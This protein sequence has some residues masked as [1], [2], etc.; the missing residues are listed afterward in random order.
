MNNR[1]ALK[2]IIG[3]TLITLFLVGC[4]GITVEPTAKP[5]IPPSPKPLSPKAILESAVTAME[6]LDSYHFEMVIHMTIVTEGATVETPLTFTGDFK[7]PDRLQGELTMD[8]LG[9]TIEMEVITI[10]GISY[11]KDPTSDEWQTTTE[12]TSPFTPE[13]FVGLEPD[14]IA[15]MEDLKLLGESVLG[16]APVYHLEGKLTTEVMENVLGE[17]EGEIKVE[18]WIGLEDGWIRQA[19]IE[20][21]L[22]EEG[23]D[24]GEI[25][26]TI[27]LTF[28]GFNMEIVIEAP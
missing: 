27:I 25:D 26:A 5:T 19:N 2:Q 17:A 28:S 16:G 1:G 22:F 10:G 15:N 11:I 9:Q 20:M 12:T 14:D 3:F 7:A 13:D 24:P 6:E 8:L 4:G 21:E 23:A 18:Y